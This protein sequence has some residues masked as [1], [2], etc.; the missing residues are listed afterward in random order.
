MGSI[1]S[2]FSFYIEN[3]PGKMFTLPHGLSRRPR[4]RDEPE[5]PEDKSDIN[6]DKELIKTCEV[7]KTFFNEVETFVE[8]WEYPGF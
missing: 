8:E 7:L 5:F 1:Y 2:L 3:K 6:E 4:S